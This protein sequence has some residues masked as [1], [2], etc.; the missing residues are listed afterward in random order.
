MVVKVYISGISGNKEVKK[1][2]QRVLMIL[3]SKNVEYTVI[4]ITEPGKESEKEFMQTHSN[5]KESKHPLP[6]Q[7]FNEDEY[8]GD[9]EDF[10]LANE[11][12]EL[13]K[14]LKVT[15]AISTAEITLDKSQSKDIQQNG[16]ASSREPSTDKDTTVQPESL[17]ERRPLT[18][19]EQETEI[20]IPSE[21]DAAAEPEN[22]TKVN[23]SDAK[24]TSE[25]EAEQMEESGDK[26][27]EKSDDQEKEE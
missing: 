1:R 25:T 14:F 15:P 2:Q 5:A 20:N 24:D 19:Q 6:P 21:V 18:S 11:I 26:N 22:D 9:Y 12:D 10:D 27:E 7:I 4:D 23:E 16:N 3:E 13:E 8:C 17:E